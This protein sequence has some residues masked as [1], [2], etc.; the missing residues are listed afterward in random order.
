MWLNA[1]PWQARFVEPESLQPSGAG[2]S[3]SRSPQRRQAILA[4]QARRDSR[5]STRRFQRNTKATATSTAIT[6]A[7]STAP[8]AMSFIARISGWSSG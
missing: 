5:G 4:A 1:A 2:R 3:E 6:L 7:T 8:A